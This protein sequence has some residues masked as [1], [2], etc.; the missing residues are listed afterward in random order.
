[1]GGTQAQTELQTDSYSTYLFIC[2][3]IRHFA[4]DFYVPRPFVVAEDMVMNMAIRT[5]CTKTYIVISLELK[6]GLVRKYTVKGYDRQNYLVGK[7]Q[8]DF[9]EEVTILTEA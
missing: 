3:I 8:R 6:H 5:D 9:S 4:G 1:M 2:L 7:N